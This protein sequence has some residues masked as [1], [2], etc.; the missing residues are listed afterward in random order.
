MSLT[1]RLYTRTAFPNKGCYS[2]SEE[3]VPTEINACRPEKID[4]RN[5]IKLM[6][7]YYQWNLAVKSLCVYIYIYI[8]IYIYSE[9]TF[10]EKSEAFSWFFVLSNI[11]IN[12]KLH[13]PAITPVFQIS[14]QN[15]ARYSEEY[16]K[17]TAVFQN[18]YPFLPRFLA[19][20]PKMFW[21]TLPGKCRTR[22]LQSKHHIPR[23]L[24]LA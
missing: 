11:F 21:R 14:G 20:H 7:K 2:I 10:Q 9:L 23:H 24:V 22:Q 1:I 4:N 3:P 13:I 19:A 17:S 15:F 18:C 12:I 6:S 8:Y 5:A 16:L